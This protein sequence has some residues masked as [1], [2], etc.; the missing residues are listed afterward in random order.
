MVPVVYRRHSLD[1]WWNWCRLRRAQLV[2]RSALYEHHK[3]SLLCDIFRLWCHFGLQR[4]RNRRRQRLAAFVHGQHEHIKSTGGS[5][6]NLALRSFGRFKARAFASRL[7][8]A[9]F[10]RMQQRRN[11][12]ILHR[13]LVGL[14]ELFFYRRNIVLT[15]ARL[16]GKKDFI[17]C[18]GILACWYA[19]QMQRRH[20]FLATAIFTRMLQRR[21][22]RILHCTFVG[23]VDLFV[24]R[25]NQVLTLA[26]LDGKR[27]FIVCKGAIACWQIWRNLLLATLRADKFAQLQLVA[28]FHKTWWNVAV[29]ATQLKSIYE[30]VLLSSRVQCATVLLKA[31]W[32]V[33]VR[34]AQLKSIYGRVL[35]SWNAFGIH[36]SWGKWKGLCFEIRTLSRVGAKIARRYTA[37]VCHRL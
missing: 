32:N 4:L 9:I 26:R 15:L 37:D 34:E 21:N 8:H 18:K 28:V 10:T 11:R 16:D 27:D 30:H 35:L 29:C 7:L 19:W 17:V 3:T 1:Q 33:A 24:Y 20:L 22:R 14:V 5:A 12:R 31:W 13:A 6:Y 36:Q 2:R 23:M 25:R